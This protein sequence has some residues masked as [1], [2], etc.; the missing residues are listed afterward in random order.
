M[1]TDFWGRASLLS[2][3]LSVWSRGVK[4]VDALHTGRSLGVLLAEYPGPEPDCSP[5]L[6]SGFLSFSPCFIPSLLSLRLTQ[7]LGVLHSS[8]LSPAPSGRLPFLSLSLWW[9][10]LMDARG[11]R[12]TATVC[13]HTC[14]SYTHTHTHTGIPWGEPCF[15]NQNQNR[16]NALLELHSPPCRTC[17]P[18]GAEPEPAG[19]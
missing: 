9:A 2:A 4:C 11:A 14:Y 13:C 12:S 15:F 18:G 19:S 8:P 16:L 1:S 5:L 17:T 10:V 3:A 6:L 7:V